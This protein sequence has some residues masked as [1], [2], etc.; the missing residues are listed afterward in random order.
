MDDFITLLFLA[1]I[2]PCVGWFLGIAGFFKSRRAL[3]EVA[4]L[5]ARLAALEH[6][7]PEAAT[8]PSVASPP[9]AEPGPAAPGAAAPEPAGAEPAVGA[10]SP[11]PIPAAPAPSP[12]RRPSLEELITLRW[13]VW[14][15]GAAL[16]LSGVFLIR[17]AVE[18]GV[19]GP[20]M[21][22]GLAAL[23]GLV[24]IGL[25]EWL[26]RKEAPAGRRLS[27]QAPPSLAAAGVAV[28]FGAAYGFGV[29]YALV[30]PVI[31]FGLMALAG[32]AGLLLSLR[33]G[34]PVGAIGLIGAFVTPALV[35]TED[36]SLPGLFA[37][38]VIVT[39]SA[40][41]VRPSPARSGSC[42]PRPWAR[43]PTRGR[44]PSSSRRRHSSI[45]HCCRR[46]HLP[47]GWAAGSP[48][49]PSPHWGSRASWWT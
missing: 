37:Y 8:A 9:S 3:A 1:L 47:C 23:L 4:V 11:S 49:S 28:L 13:G 30:P 34:Q 5:R 24:L 44:R 14:L 31:G 20:A 19:M 26:A 16:L 39:A 15:G 36:P 10:P 7:S 33:R 48:G 6:R 27:D 17:Y 45:W 38:L 21:R 42:W 32:L 41:G 35:E 12:V 46:R 2:I 22:C 18:L 25:A 29:Y 40:L 43:R